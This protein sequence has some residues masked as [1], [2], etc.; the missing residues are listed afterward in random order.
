MWVLLRGL[1]FGGFLLLLGGFRLRLVWG[2]LAF[3]F[4]FFESCGTLGR[5][6]G[7]FF[8]GCVCCVWWGTGG[9]VNWLAI[10]QTVGCFCIWTLENNGNLQFLRI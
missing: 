5:F 3:L 8:F 1:V 9:G 2:F 6:L 7:F 10:I 4:A